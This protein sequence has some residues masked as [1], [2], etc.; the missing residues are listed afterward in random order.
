MIFNICNMS[1]SVYK[2]HCFAEIFKLY[3]FFNMF[4][5]HE[6]PLVDLFKEDLI[7][8][9]SEWSDISFTW[10]TFFLSEGIY[11]FKVCERDTIA[12]RSIFYYFN[13]LI[14][15]IGDRKEIEVFRFNCFSQ[16]QCVLHG[17]IHTIPEFMADKNNR[18]LLDF[19][20]LN[21]CEYFKKFI[22]GSK[23]T[24]EKYIRLC[25]K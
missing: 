19:F 9:V 13:N 24:R 22:E 23:T 15:I 6:Y 2:A 4:V 10:Y 1:D 18:H 17:L 8:F 16:K 25:S 12:H 21:K 11:C 7:L 14:L 5:F 3:D 20:R